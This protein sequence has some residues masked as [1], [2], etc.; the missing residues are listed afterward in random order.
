[1]TV[2]VWTLIR[3]LLMTLLWTATFSRLLKLTGLKLRPTNVRLIGVQF[4]CPLMYQ[5]SL[6]CLTYMHQI[7]I[8]F[9]KIISDP[10]H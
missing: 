4:P 6:I 7:S 5:D 10:F 3:D 9:V 2:W 1:M 8:S